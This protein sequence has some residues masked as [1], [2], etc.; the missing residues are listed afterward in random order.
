MDSEYKREFAQA[1]LETAL[2]RTAAENMNEWYETQVKQDSLE[3]EKSIL[4]PKFKVNSCY[5]ECIQDMEKQEEVM[6]IAVRKTRKALRELE[7]VCPGEGK[8]RVMW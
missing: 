1:K 6:S 4:E 8:A 7:S 5:A 2:T 3:T